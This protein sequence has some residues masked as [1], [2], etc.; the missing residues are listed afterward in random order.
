M[1]GNEAG[2]R[3][4]ST[5]LGESG[6]SRVG[7]PALAPPALASPCLAPPVHTHASLGHNEMGPLA[8]MLGLL[9]KSG[10]LDLTRPAHF[11]ARFP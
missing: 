6:N 3:L 9:C 1:T 4:V 8:S 2:C 7:L 10:Q 11:P 5:G